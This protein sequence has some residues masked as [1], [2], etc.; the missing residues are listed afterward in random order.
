[1]GTQSETLPELLILT[2]SRP[3]MVNKA[4]WGEFDLREGV[5]TLQPERMKNNRSFRIPLGQ[6]SVE[7][8]GH[9]KKARVNDYV[10]PGQTTGHVAHNAINRLLGRMGWHDRT[11]AHGFR[12]TFRTWASEETNHERDVCEMALAHSLGD[13]TYDAYQRGDLLKKRRELM[14]DWEKF[15]I[16]SKAGEKGIVT[17]G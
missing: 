6:R 3:A 9:M 2:A 16:A 11:V 7:I 12:S 5:W 15:V 1:M 17:A 8:L 14:E 13:D 4:S 10:F